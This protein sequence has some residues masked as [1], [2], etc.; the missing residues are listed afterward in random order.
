M[1]IH[2]SEAYIVFNMYLNVQK[3]WRIFIE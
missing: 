2:V 1:N 3:W